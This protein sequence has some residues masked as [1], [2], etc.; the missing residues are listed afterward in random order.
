M[1]EQIN[2]IEKDLKEVREALLGNEYNPNG[3]I[4]ACR[5]SGEVSIK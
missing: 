3:F 2:N 4:K 5:E 1:Q